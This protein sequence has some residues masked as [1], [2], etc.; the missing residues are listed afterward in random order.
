M[1][2]IQRTDGAFVARQGSRSS[3]TRNLQHA[4]PF[5]TREGAERECCPGNERVRHV[6]SVIYSEG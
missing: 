1:Y 3:Y 6:D 5:A 2:V 4:R